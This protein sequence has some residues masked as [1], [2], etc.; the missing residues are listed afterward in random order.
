MKRIWYSLLIFLLTFGSA[1]GQ[2]YVNYQVNARAQHL[3][4]GAIELLR[5]RQFE[6]GMRLMHLAT[7]TDEK[8]LDAWL[9]LAGVHGE[10]KNYDS[11]VYYYEKVFPMDTAYTR[12]FYLPYSIN[13][14][15]RG[16]FAKAKKAVE[17]FLQKPRLDE[18]SRN[19][20]NYRLNAYDFALEHARKYSGRNFSPVNLGDSINSPRSEYYPS[21]TINDSML[22]FTRR[23]DGWREDFI[24]AKKIEGETYSK[25]GLVQGS[26]NDEPSKGGLMI[27][28]DGEWLIFAG[29]FSGQ[30]MGDFDLYMCYATPEGW[31][32]PF[33]LGPAINTEFWESSPTLSPDKNALYFS[34]NRPDG[35]GG[36]DLYVS[37]RQMDGK[38]SA[39]ENMGEMFN[40]RGDELAPFI[41][42]DNQTLYFT[43]NGHPG[44]GGSDIYLSRKQS[45]GEWSA[46]E[47]LGYPINTIQDDGSLA[48]SADGITA[49]FASDRSDTRG[50]L[51]LYKF[52]LP[53]EIRPLR[54]LWVQGTVIDFATRQGLPSAI[55][56]KETTSGMLVQKVITDETGNYLVTL[57][58][59]KDYS[60]TVNRKGYLFYTERIYLSEGNENGE[61]FTKDILLRP[62]SV[63]AS[64]VMNHILFETN[65]AELS[66]QS[67]I[68]LDKLLGW[69]KDNPTMRIGIYGH[70]DDVGAEAANNVLSL[71]RAR[72]VMHYLVNHGILPNRI[73]VRGLGETKPIASNAS[74]EG[75]AL[76]RRTEIV[77]LAK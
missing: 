25:A 2:W 43:S 36:K 61:T 35:F 74:E 71:A 45:N 21:F 34:S 68:E 37:Y 46:P 42:A 47:N 9:S 76:N 5:E 57:P 7:K 8:F 48:V 22:V 13:L 31:S 12:D 27:S 54:T 56:L 69:M 41:H 55:E 44:Y 73:T 1:H 19:A 70:T 3:Y 18:R 32:D 29:N 49:F 20:A 50:G 30:G 64:F 39:A 10:Q 17:T 72:S 11:A 15:G 24:R 66:P 65:K 77:V 6:P 67:N 16:E 14:A 62:I 26:L 58:T 59:G 60:F 40:T 28:Q 63:N 4:N 51:D 75:K 38:W 52:E 53:R 23:G 33:N